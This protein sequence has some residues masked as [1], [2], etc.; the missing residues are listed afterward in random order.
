MTELKPGPFLKKNKTQNIMQSIAF[1]LVIVGI[2][3]AGALVY[4]HFH[5]NDKNNLGHSKA[6]KNGLAT[7]EDQQKRYQK[8]I[9]KNLE[10]GDTEAYMLAQLELANNFATEK[11]YDSASDILKT[12]ADKVPEDKLSSYY[13]QVKYAVDKGKNNKSAQRKDLEKLIP[14]LKAVNQ[15]TTAEFYQKELDKL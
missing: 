1:A 12:I 7:A 10:Q 14:M 2:V 6:S 11:N 4:R 3:L 5:D 15:K 13:Y 9:D 8:V